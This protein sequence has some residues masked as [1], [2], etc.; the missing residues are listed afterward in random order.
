[1]F[2]CSPLNGT[3]STEHGPAGLRSANPLDVERKIYGVSS[4][5]ALTL[6]V[7]TLSA[8]LYGSDLYKIGEPGV[9]GQF[10]GS[11]SIPAPTQCSQSSVSLLIIDTHSL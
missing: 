7:K 3:K 11:L 5:Q 1:V 2:G 10:G 4:Q 9:Y 8:Y 6:G